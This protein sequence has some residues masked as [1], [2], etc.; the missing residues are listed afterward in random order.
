[1]RYLGGKSRIRKQVAGYLESI[2][3]PEQV[4]FEPFVGGAWVLQEMTGKRIASDGN[5]ALIEM[6]KALQSGWTPPESIT[7]EQYAEYK[8]KQDARDPMTAFV[9]IGCSF[10]GKWFGGFASSKE[11]NYCSNAKNSLSSQLPKIASCAFVH[12]TFDTHLVG[13]GWL[14]YCDPPYQG[15]T[16]YGAFSGFDH[17]KFWATMRSW[18]VNNTVIISEYSAPKD[19]ESMLEIETK[20]DMRFSD[21][22]KKETTEKLFK[23]KTTT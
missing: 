22:S 13:D 17:D 23:L 1:M 10:A 14:I 2:R 6:Y 16:A 21:G 12:G 5:F 4:Y 11:R 9:G 19:F 20:T 18:S 8:A 7:K 15:T 3:K